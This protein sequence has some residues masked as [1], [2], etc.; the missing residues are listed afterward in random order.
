MNNKYLGRALDAGK[1]E[2]NKR[3][4]DPPQKNYYSF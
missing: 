3:P 1:S 2:R 4:V